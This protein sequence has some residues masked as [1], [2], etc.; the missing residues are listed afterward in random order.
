MTDKASA[1]ATTISLSACFIVA[2]LLGEFIS[3]LRATRVRRGVADSD[4]LTRPSR[5]EAVPSNRRRD[6]GIVC[7]RC[8]CWLRC[9]CADGRR[10]AFA[11]RATAVP[12]PQSSPHNASVMPI[13]SVRVQ[14]LIDRLKAQLGIPNPVVASLVAKNERVA[15]V[16]RIPG[17]DGAF[18]LVLEEAFV[19][20]LTD[21]ELHAVVAHELG[22]SGSFAPSVSA[23]RRA[24][25]S[26]R[27]ARG[28]ARNA[29]AVMRK[30]GN[31]P[32]P[33]GRSSICRA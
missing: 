6:I 5:G 27:V 25:Q 16:E 12:S 30:C 1:A 20:G 4:T 29:D 28:P 13:P 2:I 18:S 3:K 33:K 26:D 9:R 14:A 10:A 32:V 11:K 7:G 8:R 17:R 19:N 23:N 31:G 24:G 15:S 22:Q 21:E